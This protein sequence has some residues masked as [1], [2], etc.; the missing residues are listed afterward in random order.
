MAR[1]IRIDHVF[2]VFGD[3]PQVVAE[4][5]LLAHVAERPEPL[6]DPAQRMYWK[7]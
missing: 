7:K 5:R 2:K 6:L 1:Q 3:A 4:V